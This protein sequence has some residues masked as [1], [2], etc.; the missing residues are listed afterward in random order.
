MRR[1]KKK[2][3][4]FCCKT[5][6]KLSK[7]VRLVFR[8]LEYWYRKQ[9]QYVCRAQT[10][11]EDVFGSPIHSTVH[12]SVAYDRSESCNNDENRLENELREVTCSNK[13]SELLIEVKWKRN[14]SS[15]ASERF[16][17][18]AC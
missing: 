11:T 12:S 14:N 17:D 8:W 3:T 15:I 7:D 16:V 1:K 5:E 13:Q 18:D 10:W 6:M 2:L 9:R 4:N